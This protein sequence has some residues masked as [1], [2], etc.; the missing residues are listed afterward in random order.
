LDVQGITRHA[1]VLGTDEFAA[2]HKLLTGTLGLSPAMEQSGWSMIA[3]PNGTLLDPY[4]PEAVPPWG[5]NDGL[6]FGFRVDDVD[7]ASAELGAAG[8]ELLGEVTRVPEM[9]YAFRHF[10]DS[11]AASTESTSRSSPSVKGPTLVPSGSGDSCCPRHCGP[12]NFCLPAP[13][14]CRGATAF[15]VPELAHSQAADREAMPTCITVQAPD[16]WA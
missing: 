9:N 3:M 15:H 12:R 11:T 2:T 5:F 8:R 10:R 6:V 16:T 4:A 13:P 7:G 14:T 1:V